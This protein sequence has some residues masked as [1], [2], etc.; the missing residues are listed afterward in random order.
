MRSGSK[1]N[2]AQPLAVIV[3]GTRPELVKMADAVRAMREVAHLDTLVVFTGQHEEL[4]REA[5]ESLDVEPDVAIEPLAPGRSLTDLLGH[6]VRELGRLSQV[7]CAACLVVQGDTASALAGALVAE[8]ANV[9]L[10]H[11]EAGVRS[12]YRDDPFPEETIRRLISSISELHLCFSE[13]ALANLMREGVEQ[14][15]ITVVPHPLRDRVVKLGAQSPPTKPEILITLHRRER[16]RER[17]DRLVRLVDWLRQ[18]SPGAS[19][20]FVWHPALDGELTDLDARLIAAGAMVVPPL[21]PDAFLERLAGSSLV[22]T[23]SAGV[24]E[25]AQLLGRPLV[26]FRVSAETRIDERPMAPL[27]VT[28]SVETATTFVEG[29]GEL[30]TAHQRNVDRRHVW[31]GR[32]IARA[33][34]D[35]VNAGGDGAGLDLRQPERLLDCRGPFHAER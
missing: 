26:I 32:A 8:M 29:L 21:A 5:A 18:T 30:A 31:A 15:A 4:M 12:A 27:C 17:V 14:E 13:V 33:V 1:I 9:P 6:V 35:F 7:A 16:R 19:I 2:G 11:V 24:A 34:E 10:I 3:L 28:E 25:E 20:S 23:D 22:I